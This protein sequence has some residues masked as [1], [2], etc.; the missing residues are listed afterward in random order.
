MKTTAHSFWQRRFMPW[1]YC[2]RC[3]LILLN[4]R[5]TKK[6]ARRACPDYLED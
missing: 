6:A 3:G 5:A 2:K 1:P 4:N